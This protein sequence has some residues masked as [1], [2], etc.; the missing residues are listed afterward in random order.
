[1]KKKTKI[2][3]IAILTVLLM[4]AGGVIYYLTQV[5]EDIEQTVSEVTLSYTQE[6]PRSS[7]DYFVGQRSEESFDP[8]LF[9]F[10]E[11][12]DYEVTLTFR[13]KPY[14]VLFHVIDDQKPTIDFLMNQVDLYQGFSIEGL[15]SVHDKTKVSVTTNMSE[16]D[17]QIGEHDF[18]VTATD[19][20]G[21]REEKCQV[22]TV[23]DTTP[24]VDLNTAINFNYDY[25]NMTL[26]EIMEDYRTKRGFTNQIAVS[27]HN[28]VTN[29]T[30][31]IN[32]D[33][34]MVAG[35]TYK[36]PLNMYY[37]EQEN[38]GKISQ[39]TTLLYREESFEEGGP[40]GDSLY[41]PGD[42][43]SIAELQFYSIVY[44]D[45]TASRIL[46]DGLGGW[47]TYREA[48][49]KYSAISYPDAYYANN[50]SVRYINDVLT[51]LYRNYDAFPELT[52]RLFGV[53]PG[54]MLKQYVNVPILQKDG[55]YG[56]AYNAAGIVFADK[57]YA[58]S[59][60]TS[61]GEAG[62]GIMGEVNLILYQ[63]AQAH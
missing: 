30:F 18:C 35:S 50:F 48:V 63:Y 38:A 49:K 54:L 34:W 5:Y 55:C 1:M 8:A 52:Q 16:D 43:I 45:N 53:G 26:E 13:E 6:A 62:P 21:N 22:V 46:F 32:P 42:R 39:S 14:T 40:I 60:Y 25:A 27:Y 58:V 12:K 44:S 37:Y 9:V 56:S 15:Y 17:F 20:S 7:S 41:K 2:I 24:K 59:V 36:L 4:I 3:L 29:E 23:Q 47:G 33:Q 51:Y 31:F 61:L 19:Q 10:D 28:F 11:I 57:P